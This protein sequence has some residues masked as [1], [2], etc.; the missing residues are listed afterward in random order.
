HHFAAVGIQDRNDDLVSR[1]RLDVHLAQALEKLLLALHL[2]I[3]VREVG[4]R[5]RRVGVRGELLRVVNGQLQ[6]VVVHPPVHVRTFTA[7]LLEFQTG[8]ITVE[9]GGARGV[10][11]SQ[12]YASEQGGHDPRWYWHSA[13]GARRAASLAARS[14]FGHS[15]QQPAAWCTRAEPGGQACRRDQQASVARALRAETP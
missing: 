8:D 6:A 10:F 2:E 7:Y 5:L 4:L 12:E 1:L 11:R 15:P 14:P 3:Q 9:S 13:V